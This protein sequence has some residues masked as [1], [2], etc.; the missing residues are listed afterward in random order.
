MA[1]KKVSRTRQK[2]LG[3]R[4]Y[5]ASIKME[6]LNIFGFIKM[7]DY[8]LLNELRKVRNDFMHEITQIT[9]ERAEQSFRLAINSLKIRI[10]DYTKDSK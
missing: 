4:D 10:G 9:N 1:E 6:M 8:V 2:K 7:E 3:G 5:T